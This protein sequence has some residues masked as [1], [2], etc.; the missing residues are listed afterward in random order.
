MGVLVSVLWSD[1]ARG[2]ARL[3]QSSGRHVVNLASLDGVRLTASRTS[4]GNFLTRT[5]SRDGRF[6]KPVGLDYLPFPYRHSV[7]V[8]VSGGAATA[9]GRSSFYSAVTP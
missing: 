4:F 1:A 7:T 5:L 2:D 9:I 8:A 6:L 3:F